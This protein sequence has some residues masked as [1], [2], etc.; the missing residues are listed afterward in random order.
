MTFIHFANGP[1]HFD[2]GSRAGE[3]YQVI[4]GLA[5]QLNGELRTWIVLVLKAIASA[6]MFLADTVFP[7]CPARTSEA[8]RSAMPRADIADYRGLTTATVCHVLSRFAARKAHCH[9]ERQ[10]GQI[11]R[12]ARGRNDL[13]R[14]FGPCARALSRKTAGHLSRP[15]SV[16][17]KSRS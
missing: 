5:A 12:P 9:P 15:N 11:D 3:W 4:R 13:Q 7:P 14:G 10:S 1:A 17:I 6:S 2:E 16:V 8:G